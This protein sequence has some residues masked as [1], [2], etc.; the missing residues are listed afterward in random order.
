[1]SSVA[2]A[3]PGSGYHH[4]CSCHWHSPHHAWLVGAPLPGWPG[5]RQGQCPGATR[6]VPQ[7]WTH[8][9][10]THGLLGVG[11]EERGMVYYTCRL[12]LK[13]NYPCVLQADVLLS[14]SHPSPM[15]KSQ[16]EHH[17]TWCCP[18]TCRLLQPEESCWPLQ[19]ASHEI[20]CV[21]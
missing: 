4:C 1:M 5:A 6:A 16:T 14:F 17:T 12:K 13:L 3:T 8:Q 7:L 2:A 11:T 15:G 9:E 10:T 20:S 21:S 19:F 18:A